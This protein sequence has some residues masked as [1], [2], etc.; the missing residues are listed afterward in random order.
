MKKLFY[1]LQII[2][3]LAHATSTGSTSEP[4]AQLEICGTLY[5]DK[6]TQNHT[7]PPGSM[8]LEIVRDRLLQMC[9]PSQTPPAVLAQTHGFGDWCPL[10][11]FSIAS[12]YLQSKNNVTAFKTG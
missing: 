12:T 10:S 4:E 1:I 2:F 5:G 3:R 6:S 7:S 11:K 9:S 8:H